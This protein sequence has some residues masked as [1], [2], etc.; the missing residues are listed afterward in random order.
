MFNIFEQPWT[1][2]IAG[3]AAWFILLL[4]HG[5]SRLWW[6]SHLVIFLVAAF[7]A[8]NKLVE[9]GIFK[10]SGT[11]TII[12]Q[13]ALLL[14]VAAL[15]SSQ[16]IHIILVYKNRWWQWFLP[17]VL[18]AAAFGFDVLIRTDMERIKAL[19][20]TAREAAEQ[21]DCEAIAAFI[22]ADYE[23][24]Y[25]NTREDLINHCRSFFW[26]PLVNKAK[27]MGLK[28]EIS[29][30]SAAVTL[31]FIIHFEKQSRIYREY[32]PFVILKMRLDLKK[33]QEG[34]WLINRAE[35]LEIDRQP[36]K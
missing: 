13:A 34:R 2:L 6:Q 15:V 12:I 26:E 5:D 33:E 21:E 3:I 16:I 20:S 31:T 9:A 17:I 32:K 7:F 19:I 4:F 28:V 29:A 30:P 27:K 11:L 14:A 22:S 1:L 36:V 23:D 25:H 24:S 18:A 10:F 8:V 35:I